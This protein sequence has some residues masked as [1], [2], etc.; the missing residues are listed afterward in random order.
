MSLPV[1]DTFFLLRRPAKCASLPF[2]VASRPTFSIGLERNQAENTLKEI[3]DYLTGKKEQIILAI[4]EFQQVADFPETGTEALLRSHIQFLPNV[5]FVF[6]GSRQHLMAEMFLSAKRPFYKSTQ[7]ISIGPI[8]AAIYY[9]FVKGHFGRAGRTFAPDAFDLIYRLVDGVTWEV[10]SVLNRLWA[11]GA[12]EVTMELV[13]HTLSEILS[14]NADDYRNI[15]ANLSRNE[16]A[17]LGAIA[18]WRRVIAPTGAD[19][20]AA[21]GMSPSSIVQTL[22]RLVLNQLVYSA[23]DGYL[24]YDRFLGLWLQSDR[25]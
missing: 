6:S 13:R 22:K 14:E 8:D 24:V 17:V 19:F 18:R 1:D 7:N 5:R 2:R 4:D 3:F 9:D 21:T 25:C 23:E 11:T 16:A 20:I 10:Q 15:I 12:T